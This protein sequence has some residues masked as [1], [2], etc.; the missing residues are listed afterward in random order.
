MFGLFLSYCILYVLDH[1]LSCPT[2][3]LDLENTCLD[4]KIMYRGWLEAAILPDFRK[5]SRYFENLNGGHRVLGKN[6]NII[7]QIE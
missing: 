6:V 7:F 4:T 1:I 2:G 5:N 3:F